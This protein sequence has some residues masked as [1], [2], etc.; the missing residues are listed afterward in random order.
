MVIRYLPCDV[1][2]SGIYRCLAP[3]RELRKRGHDADMPP[4]T[5]ERDERG[6]ETLR[7][8]INHI[9]DA[10]VY[11][12]QRRMESEWPYLAKE[13]RERGKAVVA[14]TDDWFLGIPSYNPAEAGTRGYKR[15]Y[16]TELD[17]RGQ[18]QIVAVK[19]ERKTASRDFLHKN[20]AE[21]SVLTVTTNFL[22]EQ[23]SRYNPNV[24][25]VPNYLDWE[26][27][28]NVTPQYELERERLRIG[29]M[30]SLV[31][32]K[33]DLMILKGI[34]G[35]FMR[36]H[37]EIDFVAAGDDGEVIHDFLE[38]PQD[39]RITYGRANFPDLPLITATMDIGLIPL[40][41]NN[42]NEAKSDLKGREYGAC[43]VP[44]IASPTESYRGWVDEGTNGFLARR[45]KD[46][47]RLLETMV[48]DAELRRAMGRSARAKAEANTIQEHVV[49]WEDLFAE[50]VGESQ[51]AEDL[52][53]CL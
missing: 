47:L 43:G 17:H 15:Y 29:W 36:R 33:N 13:L 21:A 31:W 11:V 1:G 46:W 41:L 53:L 18:R 20:F 27:W 26:M 7:F 3:A 42:F 8:K 4:H 12:L 37:P 44:C 34:I 30:G 10:D 39:Q 22:A 52:F 48:S 9:P 25:V 51:N 24:R 45:P 28:E 16:A 19:R 38:I 14:E 6:R 32:R 40:E 49:V 5:L 35:P 23:Y 2:G 50:H